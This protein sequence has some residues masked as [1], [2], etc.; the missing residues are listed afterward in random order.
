MVKSAPLFIPVVYEMGESKK[1]SIIGLGREGMALAR[2]LV[3]RGAT[4]TVS[5]LKTREELAERIEGLSEFLIRF[6]LGGHPQSL[7]DADV[8]YVSP[9]VPQDIPLLVEA[10]KRGIPISSETRLFFSLCPAPIIGITGSSGKGT[11]AT[12]VAQ[13]LQAAGRKTYMGENIGY[14]LIEKVEEIGPEAIVVAELSSFQLEVLDRSPHIASI[15]NIRPNHLDR[16]KS[17][18]AYTA[19][20]LNVLRYQTADDWA[21]L[22]KDD[23]ITSQFIDRCKGSVLLFSRKEEVEGA[24]IRGEKVFIY[25]GGGEEEVCHRK[26]VQLFGEHNLENILAACAISAA[27]GAPPEAM[28]SACTTSK[29]LEHRLEFVRELNGVFYYNDSLATSPDRTIAALEAFDK[30]IVLL[31]GGRNKGLPLKGLASLIVQKV[32]YLVLF[33]E[34]ATLLE[35]AVRKAQSRNGT[36]GVPVIK[37]AGD[38]LEKAVRLAAEASRPGDVVL[39]SPAGTS[40][41]MYRDFAERGEHFKDLVRNLRVEND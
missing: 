20:K 28:A 24:F 3:Q 10:R 41:D 33:G 9:G 34:Q 31:G 22:N 16:H 21:I 12:L 8:I 37:Q 13:I 30:P 7:L 14:P 23:P 17:M 39:F 29:G 36:R 26:D 38:D 19:A 5:D 27:A 25:W 15:L 35:E 32:R 40:Y 1:V 18:E 2:F 6:K 4:V 11:T